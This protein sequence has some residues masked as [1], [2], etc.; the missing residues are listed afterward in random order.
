MQATDETSR[1]LHYWSQVEALTAPDAEAHGERGDD[2]LITYVRRDEFP[3]H[4]KVLS[5]PHKHFV[6]FGVIPRRS[7]EAEL[8]ETL[9]AEERSADDSGIYADHKKFTFMGL[10]QT[11][12][13]GLPQAGTLEVAAFAPA[14]AGLK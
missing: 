6:R 12:E 7:Y 4:Q 5:L 1:T 9:R 10:F 11:D 14:F 2:F 8:L 3:W 13:A